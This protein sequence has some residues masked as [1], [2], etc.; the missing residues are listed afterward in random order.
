MEKSRNYLIDNQF[1]AKFITKFCLINIATSVMI[2]VLIYWFNRRT[3]TV[4]FENLKIVVKSTADFIQPIISMVV[5]IATL[6]VAL[7]TIVIVLF[8]SHRISGPLYR[9][10]IEIE[11]ITAKDLSHPIRVR[12]DDQLQRFVAECETMRVEY[13]RTVHQVKKEWDSIQ[14][15]LRQSKDSKLHL[16]REIDALTS[17]LEKF[18]T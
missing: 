16:E 7:A 4:A 10:M 2:G 5:V 1:Q 6:L 13:Q 18:K 15:A 17:E 14:A 3:N 8:T 11:K 9:L 12:A